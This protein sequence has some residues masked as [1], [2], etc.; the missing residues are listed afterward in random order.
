MS[1]LN[2]TVVCKTKEILDIL[3]KNRE[4]H[5]KLVAE[6][7]QGYVKKAK[8]SLKH[9]LDQLAEGKIVSL[10]FNITVPQDYTSVYD[11]AIQM[12]K[13]HQNDT[14]QLPAKEVR[15]L[16]QDE[17]DWMSHFITSN[18]GYSAS[19]A[20]LAEEKGYTNDYD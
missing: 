18:S 3:F 19:T 16:V 9:R 8:E 13:L 15:Q 14:I 20:K 1:S 2:M 7:R 5:S 6:A 17:W 11:T 12:L 10:Q 4:T